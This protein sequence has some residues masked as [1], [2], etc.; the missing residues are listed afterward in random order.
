MPGNLVIIIKILNIIF[1]LTD[2]TLP[3]PGG[4]AARISGAPGLKTIDR[5]HV[6]KRQHI[7]YIVFYDAVSPVI[8]EQGRF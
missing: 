5:R 7:C 1:G 2:S 8:C 6:C 3:G 4:S